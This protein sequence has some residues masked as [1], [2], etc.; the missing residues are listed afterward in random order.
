[1]SAPALVPSNIRNESIAGITYHIQGE[2]VPT[3]MVEIPPNNSIYFEHHVL[4]WKS[5]KLNVR[6]KRMKGAMKR[7]FAGLPILLTGTTGSG[8]VALSRDG[9]GQI[10][11]VH[12]NKGQAIHVREHQFL[13]ATQNISYSFS[14]VR[15]FS[16][17][18]FGASGFFVDHFSAPDTPG[19]VWLH[20][21]GNMFE[22]NLKQGE[23][24]DVEPSAWVYKDPGVKLETKIQGLTASLLGATNTRFMFNRFTGPGRLGIQS[25]SVYMPARN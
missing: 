6:L 18:F 20:G 4:L 21:Y 11:P 24:I 13:A 14:M 15:G 25:M 12:L 1:M 2:L 19:V 23:Q 3:L 10:C 7:M 9:A 8:H 5:P 17:L 22:I 16:N